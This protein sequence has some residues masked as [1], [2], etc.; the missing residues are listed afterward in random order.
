MGD[1]DTLKHKAFLEFLKD[2]QWTQ[3]ASWWRLTAFDREFL[4]KLGI[5]PE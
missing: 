2:R 4:K 3:M 1:M 5:A